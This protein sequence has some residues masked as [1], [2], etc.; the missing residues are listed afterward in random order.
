[1][2]ALNLPLKDIETIRGSDLY[3]P[4][5]AIVK[6]SLLKDKGTYPSNLFQQDFG[7]L[8]DSCYRES[9]K[10]F[11]DGSKADGKCG[12]AIFVDVDPPITISSKLPSVCS[13]FTAEL[14]AILKAVR[15][16][17]N[18][19]D[20][21]FVIFSDSLSALRFLSGRKMDHCI[22]IRI[23]KALN[24]CGKS[25]TFEW[26][27]GHSNIRG[28]DLADAAAKD[29]LQH[30]TIV[31]P[32]LVFSDFQSL[33]SK[34]VH[35]RWQADWSTKYCRLRTFKPVLGDWKSAYRDNR[36]D[37]KVLSRLRN[38]CCKFAISHHF[39][40]AVDPNPDACR[41][42]GVDTTT[43]HI[44]VDCP[45]YR[46]HRL[47]LIVE[48]NKRRLPLTEATLLSDDFNHRLLFNYLKA[49]SYYSRI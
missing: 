33:A 16:I 17:S 4:N 23:I 11:T 46:H 14:Y 41:T 31:R 47:P 39:R 10:I 42:C 40:G 36:S 26:V 34:A 37:E 48:L 29:A 13:V 21:N 43:R 20:T 49:I 18:S 1:M 12:F 35:S 38:G 22:K 45:V 6:Y 7:C 2:G 3:V 24:S 44:L 8:V 9:I 5:N 15:F 25:V 27:P 32:P 19:A 28:N 30:R